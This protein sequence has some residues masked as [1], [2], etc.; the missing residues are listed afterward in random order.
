MLPRQADGQQVAG[1]GRQRTV[2]LGRRAPRPRCSLRGRPMTQGGRLTRRPAGS[3]PDIQA[4][5]LDSI[6]WIPPLRATGS[7]AVAAARRCHRPATSMD[8][9]HR[10]PG[11]EPPTAIGARALPGAPR[12]A[13]TPRSTIRY[14]VQAI[15]G[16]V[17]DRIAIT[18]RP[19][20]T[21]APT[22]RAAPATATS[23]PTRA[24]VTRAA[25]VA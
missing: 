18:H 12:P 17:G 3:R 14:A 13:R 5:R 2:Q 20:A 10:V 1:Q 11:P 21:R 19:P 9:S 16:P 7:P 8:R 6:R 24:L 22:A 23:R 15:A 4:A 25:E